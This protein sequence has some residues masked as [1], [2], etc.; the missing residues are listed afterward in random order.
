MAARLPRCGCCRRISRRVFHPLPGHRRGS[1]VASGKNSCAASPAQA[2]PDF[3]SAAVGVGHLVQRIFIVRVAMR[4]KARHRPGREGN[5][6]RLF[7][8]RD[9]IERDLH[10]VEFVWDCSRKGSSGLLPVGVTP[11]TLRPVMLRLFDDV[12]HGDFRV[13]RILRRRSRSRYT[14]RARIWPASWPR[15][16]ISRPSKPGGGIPGRAFWMLSAVSKK[17]PLRDAFSHVWLRK[18][19]LTFPEPGNWHSCRGR[20]RRPAC[21]PA[22][23]RLPRRGLLRASRACRF[24]NR[25]QSTK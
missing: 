17:I 18:M 14:H 23:C 1:P 21:W 10:I 19:T 4:N 8:H 25:S 20:I 2:P 3:R 16:G 24:C 5:H 9:D 7:V 6:V 22:S 15:F 11:N 12:R 13:G